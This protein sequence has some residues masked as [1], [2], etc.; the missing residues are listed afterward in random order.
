MKRMKKQWMFVLGLAVATVGG[1]QAQT[2]PAANSGRDQSSTTTNA[3][4][5][6]VSTN[7]DLAASAALSSDHSTLLQ[8]LQAAS[9]T[10]M[11]QKGGPY[12]VFAPTNAA[13][14]KIDAATLESLM[15]PANRQ[16]L[17]QLLAYHVVRGRY[18]S[19][20]LKNNQ[21]LTTVQGGKL[22]VKKEGN[23]LAITDAAGNTSTVNMGDI[24]ATNGIVH[25]VDTVLMPGALSTGAK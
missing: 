12:T 4:T 3:P 22:T 16:Q 7:A 9:L 19:A 8:A 13:F 24:T 18:T 10:D 5:T 1:V 21:T 15:Q 23:T 11:A 25:S 17:S 14:A 6:G 20:T 2:S